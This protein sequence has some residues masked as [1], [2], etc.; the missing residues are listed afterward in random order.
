MRTKPKARA[1]EGPR[2][3]INVTPLV[4][5]CLVLLVI[6]MVVTPMLDHRADVELPRTESPEKLPDPSQRI[7]LAIK[8]DGTTWYQEKW[9]P[10]KELGSRL[11]QLRKDETG[12]EVVVVADAH[13]DFAEVRGLMRLLH[14]AGFSGARLAASRKQA[15]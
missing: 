6:F 14:E 1:E 9:L 12:K 8:R 11:A 13:L 15:S 4:D 10:P 7:T 2:G 3:D 5:V